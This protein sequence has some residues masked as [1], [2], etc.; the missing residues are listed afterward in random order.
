MP[1]HP[2]APAAKPNGGAVA[3]DEVAPDAEAKHQVAD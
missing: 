2:P 3:V 1:V